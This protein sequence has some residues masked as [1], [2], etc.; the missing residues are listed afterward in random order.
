MGAQGTLT[1]TELK[2]EVT[3]ALGNRTD[4][5]PRLTRFLNLAQQRIARVHDFQELQQSTAGVFVITA[6]PAVDKVL[7]LTLLREIYSL[8]VVDDSQS[9]KLQQV[10][11]RQWDR[12]VPEPEYFSRNIP[13]HYTIWS[14]QAEMWPV[15]D[16]AYPYMVRWTSWPTPFTDTTPTMVSDF[17]AKDE[18]LI[19]LATAYAFDSLSKT[20]DADRKYRLVNQ[21]FGEA[22][23]MDTTQPDLEFAPT[24]EIF[25]GSNT[26]NDYWRDPFN[27]SGNPGES[28]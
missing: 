2:A 18:L 9:V 24:R 15:P 23:K 8:R 12:T 11:T 17:L 27:M 6:N 25:R 4:M 7:S 3:S 10:S 28:I 13:S 5:A 19:Q 26:N 16:K 14:N 22:I 20:D 21:L 1:L